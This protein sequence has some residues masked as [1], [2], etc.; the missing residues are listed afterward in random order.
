MKASNSRREEHARLAAILHPTPDVGNNAAIS[1]E[2]V[3]PRERVPCKA[4]IES[5][6]QTM[7]H[8]EHG[9]KT[10]GVR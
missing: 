8:C 2:S 10:G 1:E 4:R 3:V 6:G 9:D 5:D 7:T